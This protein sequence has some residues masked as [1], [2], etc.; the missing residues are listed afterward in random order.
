MHDLF[1]DDFPAL[2]SVLVDYDGT[3]LRVFATTTKSSDGTLAYERYSL[4]SPITM[5]AKQVFPSLKMSVE[6][7]EPNVL[8]GVYRVHKCV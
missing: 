8:S 5:D 6:I 7:S 3:I 4:V 1:P 2:L